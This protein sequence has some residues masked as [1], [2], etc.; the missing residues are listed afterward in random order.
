MTC[1]VLFVH[2]LSDPKHVLSLVHVCKLTVTPCTGHQSRVLAGLHNKRHGRECYARPPRGGAVVSCKPS[3][4]LHN[5][6]DGLGRDAGELGAYA[7]VLRGATVIDT[8]LRTYVTCTE[9]QAVRRRVKAD[10]TSLR[11]G[12]AK[13]RF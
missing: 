4:R 10:S 11:A 13:N 9:P 7:S 2:G 3:R 6:S 8:P 12:L 5:E 1:F